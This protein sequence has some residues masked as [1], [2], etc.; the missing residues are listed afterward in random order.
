MVVEK[1]VIGIPSENMANQACTSI[2]TVEIN[3]LT[4]Q[5]MST[6]TTDRSLSSMASINHY[7][8]FS[9][10]QQENCSN[11]ASTKL[12]MQQAQLN[13][14]QYSN[15]ASLPNVDVSDHDG[16]T[17]QSEFNIIKDDIIINSNI[18]HIHIQVILTIVHII[19]Y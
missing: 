18:S 15:L 16:N 9:S 4:S 11:N 17:I 12:T 3:S 19:I 10:T 13:S 2:L 6:R 8:S 5:L 14:S 1:N 7:N